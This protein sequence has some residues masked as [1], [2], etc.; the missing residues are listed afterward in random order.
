MPQGSR[1]PDIEAIDSTC[2]L[3]KMTYRKI[4]WH[5][6]NG[7]N[8]LNVVAVFPLLR[9]TLRR[10]AEV[11]RTAV[12]VYQPERYPRRRAQIP[13]L[14]IVSCE[15]LYTPT[16]ID[17]SNLGVTAVYCLTCVLLDFIEPC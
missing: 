12:N 7:G 15:E 13:F 9:G 14:D 5:A 8:G 2:L 11:V 16:F 3:L 1:H 4:E 10:S 17:C 6:L